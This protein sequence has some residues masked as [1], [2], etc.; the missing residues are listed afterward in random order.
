VFKL[1]GKR[2]KS[3]TKYGR[4]SMIC[5]FVSTR[6]QA[7]D[8]LIFLKSE[9]KNPPNILIHRITNGG[10]GMGRI[11]FVSDQHDNLF[12]GMKFCKK[13]A[14][15]IVVVLAASFGLSFEEKKRSDDGSITFKFL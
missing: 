6:I 7:G 1:K 2:E 15:L 10:S 4:F 13:D 11:D 14:R 5:S 3:G 8:E 12:E 9:S